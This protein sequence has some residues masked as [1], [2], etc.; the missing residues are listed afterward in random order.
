M[1]VRSA[2]RT[3]PG[4]PRWASRAAHVAALTAVPSGLWR[5]AIAVGIPVGLG[6]SE[7]RQ[8][9]VPGWGTVALVG[10]SLF[11]EALAFL[12]LGLVQPWGEVWP[13]WLPLLRGRRVPVAAAVVPA[14]LGALAVT[15]YGVLFVWSSLHADMDVSDWGYGLIIV[16]YSPLLLWGPL[17]GAVMVHYYAR[18]TG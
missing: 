4:V 16:L 12:S 14:A 6:R 9:H 15:V 13:R 8:M 3:V 7:L 10:L 18:R 11:A 1:S 17:L 5:V 2:F